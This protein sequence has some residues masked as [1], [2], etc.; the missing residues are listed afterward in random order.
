M[1]V[2]TKLT[3]EAGIGCR[4]Y[5]GLKMQGVGFRHACVY[6]VDA[7]GAIGCWVK[8]LG[9]SQDLGCRV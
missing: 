6:H 7:G 8:D 3:R 4:V 5:V 2:Y 9:C 1:C